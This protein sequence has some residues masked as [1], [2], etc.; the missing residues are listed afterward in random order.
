[1]NIDDYYT[2]LGKLWKKLNLLRKEDKNKSV[3]IL[4]FD[5]FWY[6]INKKDLPGIRI[7]L[8][9]SQ[10]K[11]EIVVHQKNSCIE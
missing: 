2:K 3:E 5:N 6:T 4:A 11:I 9:N 8:K 10:F 1:M 7:K